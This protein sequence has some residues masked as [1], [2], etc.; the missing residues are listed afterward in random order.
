[1]NKATLL[2]VL[3]F[4]VE[5]DQKLFRFSPER[6]ACHV[7]KGCRLPKPAV[8]AATV[9]DLL[10]LPRRPP[11]GAGDRATHRPFGASP[12]AACKLL[13]FRLETHL[14]RVYY[15]LSSGKAK[16]ILRQLAART[17]V[18]LRRDNR[19]R[20]PRTRPVDRKPRRSAIPRALVPGLVI[21]G[22]CSLLLATTTPIYPGRAA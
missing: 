20:R 9:L 3:R 10:D 16:A 2:A 19:Q 15:R 13:A 5:P 21:G 18:G 8:K 14:V 17:E 7:R 12:R 6:F 11:L 4:V 22:G 1:M